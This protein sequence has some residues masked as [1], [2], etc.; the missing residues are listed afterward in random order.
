LYLA[1]GSTW[2]LLG[3]LVASGGGRGGSA[4]FDVKMPWWQYALTQTCAITH[5]LRLSVW[6]H[7]LVFDYGTD[8]LT[9]AWQV[10]P[11]AM[12]VA[13]LVIGTAISLW[14]WP[15]VGFVGCWFFAILAP[16]SSIVPVATQ[17]MAEHRMYLPLA[18]VVVLGVVGIRQLVGRRTI[19][20]AAVLAIALG[21]LTSRRNQDYRSDFAIWSD[22]VAKRP[23]NA[24]AQEHLG[25]A[26]GQMGR[27]T[28]AI[29]HWEEALRIRP[30]YAEAHGNLGAALGRMG[31]VPEAIEHLEEAVRVDPDYADAHYDLGI[32]LVQTGRIDDAIGQY[33]QALRIRPDYAEAHGNLGNILLQR[34]QVPEAIE[35][36]EHALR[37]KPGYAAAHYNLGIALEKAG[38][39]PEAIQYYEQA[40]KLRPDFT[41]A[42]DALT[43]LQAGQ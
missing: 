21:V 10:V 26:L 41:A 13:L 16:S 18:A 9:S 34:G 25:V 7:S 17:T 38:R 36:Y 40:L 42:R 15:V 39:A 23:W 24:R 8:V 31:R 43:R 14:R 3:Y 37:V 22:T 30:G 33:E 29:E 2:I 19:A 6:P 12:I 11:C 28:E 32:A 5:Y 20:V 4:G 27:M 1:L 35:H